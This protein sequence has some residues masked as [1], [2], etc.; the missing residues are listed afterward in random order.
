MSPVRQLEMTLARDIRGVFGVTVQV[1]GDGELRRLEVKDFDRRR[2]EDGGG[3]KLL[4]RAEFRGRPRLSNQ[5]LC[6]SRRG[7]ADQVRARGDWKF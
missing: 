5:S 6:R 3:E 4:G 1:M 2:F 7:C